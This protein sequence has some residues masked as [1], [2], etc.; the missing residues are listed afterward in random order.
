MLAR[1]LLQTGGTHMTVQG[2]VLQAGPFGKLI[3]LLLVGLS[4]WSWAIIWDR[5]RRYRSVRKADRNFLGAFRRIAP[6]SG[7]ELLADHHPDSM[8]A[9]IARAGQR[10][11]DQHP[12]DPSRAL[13]RLEI[14]QRVMERAAT[15]EETQLERGV[16]I[17]AT[18]GSVSP[19]IG[20]MGTVWGVMTAF[21][22]I[23]A[24]GSAALAV[25]A[26]GIAEALIT[27]IAGIGAAVP[28]VAAY[29]HLLGRL[30]E[31]GNGAGA[32]T[33]EFLE[34]EMGTRRS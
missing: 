28:A 8:L 25:V 9:R 24:Q 15:D 18:V 30:R 34:R 10:A 29:N 5:T 31:F 33:G 21:L 23:G 4:V 11:L 32:F 22:N 6:G 7:L 13:L 19:F 12:P 14:V 3:L 16:G 27:T 1:L 26:P 20:L 2:L 17:L